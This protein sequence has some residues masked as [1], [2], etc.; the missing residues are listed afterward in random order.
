MADIVERCAKHQMEDCPACMREEI[1]RLRDLVAK[2]EDS[3]G[4]AIR[5]VE[6]L[7]HTLKIEQAPTLDAWQPIETAPKD[8]TNVLVVHDETIVSEAAFDIQ[9]D[10]WWLAQTGPHDFDPSRA[11]Y[12][13]LWQPMPSAPIPSTDGA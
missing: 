12:P 1:E 2:R 8:G 3:L 13:T 7:T 11:I 6:R 5:Q 9:D 4:L 10:N